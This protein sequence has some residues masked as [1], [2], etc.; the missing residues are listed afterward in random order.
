MQGGSNASKT[1]RGMTIT[2]GELDE[3]GKCIV[4]RPSYHDGGGS[5]NAF[6]RSA[7]PT[8]EQADQMQ[9]DNM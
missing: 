9:Y 8:S 3:H 1:A 2:S 4:P 5:S 6:P 7:L